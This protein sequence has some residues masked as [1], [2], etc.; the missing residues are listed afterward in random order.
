M[1]NQNP[2][3]PLRRTNPLRPTSS[4]LL[5]RINTST[6][7]NT[8]VSRHTPT[9][10]DGGQ[11]PDSVAIYHTHPLGPNQCCSAVIKQIDAPLATVWS[12]VRRFDN[13]QA[14]KH[15]LRSCHLLLGD[16]DV[17]TLREVQVV[18][19]LPAENST[20]RLEILDE[21]QHVMSFS[22]IGGDHRLEN[23][24]SVTTLHPAASGN[25]T[26]VVES[27]VVDIPQGNTR[28]ETRVFVDTILI[29]NLKSLTRIAMNLTQRN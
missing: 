17:G 8:T 21:E 29:C 15:F 13:P 11:I 1:T 5:Q 25:G 28:E 6:S 16:G 18:S 20:E 4:I 22:V 9:P 14:Y 3:Q 7:T 12:V 26:V 10:R 24:R 19:G 2:R 23:Y 27:Y